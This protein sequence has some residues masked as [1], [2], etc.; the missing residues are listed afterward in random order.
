MKAGQTDKH[1]DR[2]RARQTDRQRV[3]ARHSGIQKA[4]EKVEYLVCA[5]YV[6]RFL[7]ILSYQQTM[8]KKKE[9]CSLSLLKRLMEEIY[10]TIGGSND[11][12]GVAGGCRDSY[13]F[14]G[15]GKEMTS[16]CWL[17]FIENVITNGLLLSTSAPSLSRAPLFPFPF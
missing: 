2:M 11:S 17:L 12:G 13:C 5:K 14:Y 16:T 4:E 1:T 9:K 10:E 15:G 8:K 3:R 6:R 7:E